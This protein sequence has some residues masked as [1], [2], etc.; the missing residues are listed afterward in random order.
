MNTESGW[1]GAGTDVAT[2]SMSPSPSV[3]V[4][5]SGSVIHEL[6]MGRLNKKVAGTDCTK[7]LQLQPEVVVEEGRPVDTVRADDGP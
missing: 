6:E 4:P 2:V 1:V 7:C 5:W 3:L